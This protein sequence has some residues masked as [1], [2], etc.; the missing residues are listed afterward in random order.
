MC[1]W[2]PRQPCTF[3]V[4]QAG[5]SLLQPMQHAHP[6][7]TYREAPTDRFCFFQF[8]AHLCSTHVFHNS[9]VDTVVVTLGHSNSQ[10]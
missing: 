3:T 10:V 7:R 1:V 9:S 8:S 4:P 2:V 6:S 5:G